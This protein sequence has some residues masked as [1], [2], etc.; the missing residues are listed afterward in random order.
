[1]RTAEKAPSFTQTC[2]MLYQYLKEKGQ[3]GD[4]N[5]VDMQFPH[6]NNGQCFPDR[7]ICP[8]FLLL[9]SLVVGFCVCV[10]LCFE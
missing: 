9:E 6:V 4:L 2:S 1:M 8:S 3:L 10:E 5:L 7:Y